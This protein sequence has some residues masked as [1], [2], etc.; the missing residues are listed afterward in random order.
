MALYKITV[1]NHYCSFK[2]SIALI[3]LQISSI[4]LTT[5]LTSYLTDILFRIAPSFWEHVVL[6]VRSFANVIYVRFL[7]EILHERERDKLSN[8]CK[9]QKEKCAREDERALR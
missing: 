4:F 3:V 2:L 5:F 6:I 9:E 1:S 7:R 8:L